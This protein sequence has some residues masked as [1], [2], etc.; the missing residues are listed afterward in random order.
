MVRQSVEP[1]PGGPVVIG[2][3]EL[4]AHV[5]T[6]PDAVERGERSPWPGPEEQESMH[7]SQY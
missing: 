1:G 6:R 3:R 2:R 5:R 4:D 7:F